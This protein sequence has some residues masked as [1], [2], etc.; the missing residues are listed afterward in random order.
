MERDLA[1]KEIDTI[2]S[3]IHNVW[4]ELNIYDINY[5]KES[6]GDP[7][8]EEYIR[9]VQNVDNTIKN[10]LDNLEELKTYWKAYDESLNEDYNGTKK[11]E[12]TN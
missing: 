4:T 1:I 2:S 9:K 10:M 7:L 6:W 12:E 3:K 5:M 8:C 11:V